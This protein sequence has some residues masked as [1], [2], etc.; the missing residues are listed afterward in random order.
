MIN[1][2]MKLSPEDRI[3]LT[4]IANSDNRSFRQIRQRYRMMLDRCHNPKS[5]YAKNYSKRGIYVCSRW[6][7]SIL[8]FLEDLGM[9]P[10]ARATIDRIDNDG[11]YEKSNCRWAT[12]DQQ[13]KNRSYRKLG[14]QWQG[15]P[16]SLRGLATIHGVTC[17]KMRLML[18]E[19][20]S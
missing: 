7:M 17:Y 2:H 13:A 18:P 19:L 1:P 16:I 20:G 8:F 12:I 15:K 11:P 14:L 6:R 3:R 5:K 4:G 10:F 9:P